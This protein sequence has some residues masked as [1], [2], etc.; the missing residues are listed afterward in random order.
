MGKTSN[1][2]RQIDFRLFTFRLLPSLSLPFSNFVNG[3]HDR[4]ER[5][6]QNTKV[7]YYTC[8]LQRLCQGLPADSAGAYLRNNND[9]SSCMYGESINTIPPT[10]HRHQERSLSWKTVTRVSARSHFNARGLHK[11]EL[12]I[13][14]PS[15]IY[16]R[17]IDRSPENTAGCCLQ[18][19]VRRTGSNMCTGER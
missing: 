7:Y 4:E 2:P 8:R 17:L 6:S 10:S 18:Q 12:A 13:I 14:P 9:R 19:T 15:I 3:R 5:R 16:D 1:A 11:R